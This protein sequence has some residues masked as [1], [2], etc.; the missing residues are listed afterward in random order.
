MPGVSVIIPAY[1]A[2]DYIGEAVES[3]LAQNYQDL[4]I[5]VVDDGSEDG[6]ADTL[7]RFP[8]VRLVKIPHSGIAAARNTGISLAGGELIAFVD[9]DDR[10][11]KDKLELQLRYLQLHPEKAMVLTRYRNFT[12]LPEK[13]LSKEQKELLGREVGR[14]MVTALIRREL[15]D[16]YGLF[17]PSLVYSEDTEWMIRVDLRRPDAMY[18]LDD[19]LYERRIHNR[20]ITLTHDNISLEMMRPLYAKALL[21]LRKEEKK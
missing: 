8:M 10:W 5:I 19:F 3:I 13:S 4:E 18:K 12:D 20:N 17:D 2:A 1:N 14:L 15:F 9:A 6:T 7:K 21:N 16:S 11:K